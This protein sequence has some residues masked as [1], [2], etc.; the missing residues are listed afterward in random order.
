MNGTFDHISTVEFEN[1]SKNRIWQWIRQLSSNNTHFSQKNT[2]MKISKKLKRKYLPNIKWHTINLIWLV[3]F[4]LRLLLFYLLFCCYCLFLMD[5]NSEKK[6]LVIIKFNLLSL[7]YN[8]KLSH[9]R[10]WKHTKPYANRERKQ[11]YM[12]SWNCNSEHRRK[13]NTNA[14]KK[15]RKKKSTEHAH[16]HQSDLFLFV[17]PLNVEYNFWNFSLLVFFGCQ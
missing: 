14:I 2:W 17:I 11:I 12:N 7:K 8:R 16:A 13:R 4:L 15:K 9:H 1:S 3:L 5:G 10:C 6:N